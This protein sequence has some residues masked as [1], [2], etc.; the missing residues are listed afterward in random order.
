MRVPI[1]QGHAV[2]RA[3]ENV[4]HAVTRAIESP[5][6][7]AG[8]CEEG[9]LSPRRAAAETMSNVASTTVPNETASL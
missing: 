6:T 9:L 8:A 2:T 1:K 7:V 5:H 3:I 4:G